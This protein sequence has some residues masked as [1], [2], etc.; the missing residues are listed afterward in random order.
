MQESV[1]FYLHCRGILNHRLLYRLRNLDDD[2]IRKLQDLAKWDR[3]CHDAILWLR[4]PENQEKF[5]MPVIE[6]PYITLTVPD[7]RYTNAIEACL[8]AN[9]L[10]VPVAVLHSHSRS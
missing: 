5:R 10:K 4:K 9:Q 6:P 1:L 2:N 3:D 7:K 8:N